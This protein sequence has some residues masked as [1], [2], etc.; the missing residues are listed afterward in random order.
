MRTRALVYDVHT[1]EIAWFV[2]SIENIECH[3]K[4]IVIIARIPVTCI[5]LTL[6]SMARKGDRERK[7]EE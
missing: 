6:C 2:Q 3:D 7:K 4:V 5:S 1:E